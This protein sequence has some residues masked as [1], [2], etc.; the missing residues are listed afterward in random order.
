MSG[1][2]LTLSGSPLPPPSSFRPRS[3]PPLNKDN[4]VNS[5]W[6]GLMRRIYLK[7]YEKEEFV[8]EV[9]E[10]LRRGGLIIYP[11]DTVYGLGADAENEDAVR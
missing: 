2:H 1:S 3:R 9:I 8:Y 10:V 11:T 5:V 7:E 6:F 4:K